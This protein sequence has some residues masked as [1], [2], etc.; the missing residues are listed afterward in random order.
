M[1]RSLN[2]AGILSDERMEDIRR[3][4]GSADYRAASG[5]MRDV[6][7]KVV[8]ETYEGQLGQL[9][10]PVVMVWGERDTEVPIGVAT[11]AG[12]LIEESGGSS[13][14]DV[15]EGIG[16]NVPL[17][18]PDALRQVILSLTDGE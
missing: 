15:L 14:L 12:R 6:L 8:N 13:T 5:V 16:H 1:L 9:A 4:S 11:S 7:V 18:A 10:C 17:E 2:R 3:R